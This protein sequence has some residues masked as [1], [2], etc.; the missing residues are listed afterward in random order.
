MKYLIDTSAW[1]EYLE[2]G[3]IG[4]KVNDILIDENNELFIIPLIVAETISKVKRKN[5]NVETAYNIIISTAENIP[6]DN[7]T[8][9]EAGLLHVKERDKNQSFGIADALII[10]TAQRNGLKILTK[11]SHFKNFRE[12]ILI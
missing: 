5:G 2:G 12:T 6:L 3:E 10:K 1:I 8:A 7:L 11:D 4:Q 9:K